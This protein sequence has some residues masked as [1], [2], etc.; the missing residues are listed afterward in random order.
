M[1]RFILLVSALLLVSA[2]ENAWGQVRY[3]VTDLTFPGGSQSFAYAINNSGQVVGSCIPSGGTYSH[4]FLYSGGTMQ[5][6]GVLPGYVA[7]WAV[8]VNSSGQV[9]VDYSDNTH[10]DYAFLYSGG[11]MQNLGTLPD[12]WS[13]DPNGI[14]DRGQVV[15]C[16]EVPNETATAYDL[17]AFLYS[18]GTM[19]DLDG[20]NAP[21]TQAIGINNSGQVVG[22]GTISSGSGEYVHAF[23]YGDGTMHD[24][25]AFPGGLQSTAYA[26]NNSGQVV[27]TAIR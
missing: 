9:A 10:R 17:H 21:G 5:D 11:T 26:I 15:G 7:G 8:G 27:G 3:T 20:L 6:L 13:T 2:N 24:L 16:A 4:P 18:N 22:Y 1:R 19:Q 12:G 23:L 25:G 14:N